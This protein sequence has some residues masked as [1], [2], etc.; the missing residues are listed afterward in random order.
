[1]SRGKVS[2]KKGHGSAA[3]L[4]SKSSLFPNQSFHIDSD[5]RLYTSFECQVKCTSNFESVLSVTVHRIAVQILIAAA[6]VQLL[7]WSK[8]EKR[9]TKNIWWV[10]YLTQLMNRCVSWWSVEGH[11]RGQWSVTIIQQLRHLG[12]FTH[13][14]SSIPSVDHAQTF[15]CLKGPC[16]LRTLWNIKENC[17]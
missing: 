16:T 10:Y 5:I 17:V 11:S 2:A 12:P 14:L 6:T 15:L 7:K 4:K 1:M 13:P 3:K 8:N 9:Q